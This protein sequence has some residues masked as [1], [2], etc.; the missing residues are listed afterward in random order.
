MLQYLKVRDLA[1]IDSLEMECAPGFTAVTGETGA[2]KSVLMGALSLLSGQRAD[3]SMIRTGAE[4]C[5]VEATLWFA[6]PAPVD[7]VLADL[8]VPP[9]EEGTLVL[10]RRILAAGG[11]RIQ[12]NGG[13]ATLAQLASLG[14]IWLE[15]HGPDAPLALFQHSAQIDMVDAFAGHRELLDEYR[16]LFREWSATRK[17][18]GEIRGAGSLSEDERAFLQS[19]ID[20]I[21]TLDVS[22]EW[23]AKLESDFKRVSHA[24]EIG[25][26]LLALEEALSGAGGAPERLTEVYRVAE[27]LR[28]LVPDEVGPL[29][30]RLDGLLV[31]LNDLAGDLLGLRSH[32]EVDPYEIE[33]VE[34]NMKAWMGLR[35]RH[36]NS[37]EAVLEKCAA[38]EERIASQGN[39]EE[40]LAR[41]EK[42][43]TALREKVAGAGER[44]TESRR[45]AAGPL[46]R[47]V[48]ALLKRLGFRKPVF[49]I[50]FE[51]VDPWTERG[52]AR[53]EYLF[54]G[55]VGQVAMPL[56]KVASSGEIA[57][58]TLALKTVLAEVDRTAVL[59]FD[60]IDAN[61]GGEVGREIGR[62]LARLSERNQVF[63]ITHLAQVAA[64]AGGH[65]VVSKEQSGKTAKIDLVDLSADAG[66][67]VSEIARMLGD[68]SSATARSHAA[69]MLE[70]A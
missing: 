15:L 14:E 45:K 68:R 64:A 8:G 60:E 47:K 25:E 43:E 4:A 20:E 51:A 33:E 57:R 11:Q 38:M 65:F 50:R 24:K 53:C 13:V 31:E 16:G 52:T 37:A 56:G 27:K 59:V 54:S 22:P 66:G 41:L 55:T 58:V 35:R 40:T 61:V 49:E 12:I 1:L 32:L 21:R 44:L 7:A 2:G 67:R 5:D 26:R 19:Q 42:E 28:D 39:V 17:K 9:T 46:A 48:G 62:E 6:E 36:G 30:D 23:V 63:S 70:G 10:R 34:H 3:R 18:I 29:A 69:E